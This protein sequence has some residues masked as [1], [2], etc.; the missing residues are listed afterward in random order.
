MSA[1]FF[2]GD[3]HLERPQHSEVPLEGEYIC[4]LESPVT[5]SA[6]AAPGKINLRTDDLFLKETFGREPAAVCLANNHV[7]D[8]GREGFLDTIACLERRGI[9][10][11]GAGRLAE[12]CR[13]P[14]LLEVGGVRVALLGYVD[15]GTQPM[16]AV[17]DGYGAAALDEPAVTRDMA[18]AREAGAGRVVVQ[19]HWGEE[20]IPLP[21]PADVRTARRLVEWGADLIIGHHSHCIQP[22]EVHRGRHIFYGLGNALFPEGG[23]ASHAADGRLLD[24]QQMKWQP[25]NRRS[26]MVRYDPASGAVRAFLLRFDSF[27]IMESGRRPE[28][29]FAFA[30]V[31]D[32][33]YERRYSRVRRWAVIRRLA[34]SFLSRPR[35]PKPRNWAWLRDVLRGGREG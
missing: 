9:G 13:N 26:L 28:E 3:V 27:L 6:Q 17:G 35:L 20:D 18:A 23:M 30:S 32:R 19:L 24:N 16:V 7:M 14:L 5:R 34:A 10:W 4:N 29:R 15:A 1:L 25:W 2:L 11:F 8:Y 22:I 12:N 33:R 31:P 21:R